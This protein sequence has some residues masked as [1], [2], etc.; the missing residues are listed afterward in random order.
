MF[1]TTEAK[2]GN[3]T[4]IRF[5]KRGSTQI[6]LLFSVRGMYSFA[7]S[8][9]GKRIAYS[10]VFLS[11]ETLARHRET[12]RHGD[13]DTRSHGPAHLQLVGRRRTAFSYCPTVRRRELW[14]YSATTGART[15]TSLNLTN[16]AATPSVSPFGDKV[17]FYAK[18]GPAGNG[19]KRERRVSPQPRWLRRRFAIW[20]P[21]ES[22]LVLPN[23]AA[24][25]LFSFKTKRTVCSQR[26]SEPRRPHWRK[27]SPASSRN[28]GAADC[29]VPAA[30]SENRLARILDLAER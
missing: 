26:P 22:Q 24:P 29:L 25:V 8:P 16:A 14:S 12:R 23:D 6:Q 1:A 4:D 2:D 15:A 11:P 10:R 21:D 9:D 7:P 3:V 18:L 5:V 20:S 30:G 28:T 27:S 19:S 17:A 13:P